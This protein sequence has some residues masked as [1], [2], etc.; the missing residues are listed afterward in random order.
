MPKLES[1]ETVLV[2][3][4]LV[5]NNYNKNQKYCLPL[6]QNKNSRQLER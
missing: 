2:Y 6:H 3:C 1:V 5:N 4:N